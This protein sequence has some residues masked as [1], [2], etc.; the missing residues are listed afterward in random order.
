MTPMAESKV[1]IHQTDGL[2]RRSVVGLV[3]VSSYLVKKYLLFATAIWVFCSKIYE[4]N[5]SREELIAFAVWFCMN[6]WMVIA[7]FNYY[8]S[9]GSLFP[10]EG[11]AQVD[12]V[13]NIGIAFGAFFCSMFNVRLLKTNKCFFYCA[14]GA[15]IVGF[16]VLWFKGLDKFPSLY[17]AKLQGQLMQF[18][19]D[20]LTALLG[21]TL[22]V[23]WYSVTAPSRLFLGGVMLVAFFLVLC[24]GRRTAILFVVFFSICIGLRERKFLAAVLG[25]FL[26][27]LLYK[28]VS[29]FNLGFGFYSQSSV[30]IL[31]PVQSQI[32]NEGRLELHRNFIANF[33]ALELWGKNVGPDNFTTEGLQ[34]FHSVI[35]DATWYAGAPGFAFSMVGLLLIFFAWLKS[36]KTA[37]GS[38]LVLFVLAGQIVG[39]PPFSNLLG[40]NVILPIIFL[41]TLRFK[42]D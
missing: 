1:L 26:A 42:I 15:L 22:V 17:Q 4:K 38:M 8:V 25:L 36:K 35:L 19:F 2:A 18:G 37:F 14:S 33:E 40:F 29:A 34:S 9:S 27:G 16:F 7:A 3:L 31:D 41:V 13:R 32:A 21:L 6:L 28:F 39:A 23:F 10:K 30:R 20:D 5:W 12:F 24:L 11:S